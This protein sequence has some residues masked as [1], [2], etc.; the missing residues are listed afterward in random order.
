MAFGSDEAQLVGQMIGALAE[1]VFVVAE[2]PV[3][4]PGAEEARESCH[5]ADCCWLQAV[6]P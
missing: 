6:A 5:S 4:A 3:K 1:A 2:P